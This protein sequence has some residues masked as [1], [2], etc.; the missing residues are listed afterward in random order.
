MPC[1]RHFVWVR[2]PADADYVIS[3]E[4]YSELLNNVSE[5]W[6]VLA[7]R[8]YTDYNSN[9]KIYWYIFVVQGLPNFLTRNIV[10]L[11][12]TPLISHSPRPLAAGSIRNVKT[13][14]SLLNI[15]H[16]MKYCFSI[17]CADPQSLINVE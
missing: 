8:K 17:F 2:Q 1:F 11:N 10:T 16:S 7:R 13:M 3:I 4:Y 12:N 15:T 5:N 14:E 6:E 9:R